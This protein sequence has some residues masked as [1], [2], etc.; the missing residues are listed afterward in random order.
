MRHGL[1]EGMVATGKFRR[2]LTSRAPTLLSRT[3]TSTANARKDGRC[4]SRCCCSSGNCASIS[5]R[6][7]SRE[8]STRPSKGKHHPAMV[9]AE[10]PQWKA[11]PTSRG[12]PLALLHCGGPAANPMA[13][14]GPAAASSSS[15]SQSHSG[16]SCAMVLSMLSRRPSHRPDLAHLAVAPSQGRGVPCGLKVA[17][18]DCAAHREVSDRRRT[19]FLRKLRLA[20]CWFSFQTVRAA[21]M[22]CYNSCFVGPA[23]PTS[24]HPVAC[25]SHVASHGLRQCVL[26]CGAGA[27]VPQ[28]R[29]PLVL[30]HAVGITTCSLRASFFE[31]AGGQLVAS[32]RPTHFCFLLTPRYS[33]H[34][35]P[36]SS[37]SKKITLLFFSAPDSA[38]QLTTPVPHRSSLSTITGPT[39]VIWRWTL[40]NRTSGSTLVDCTLLLFG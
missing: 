6:W 16:L 33:F 35:L 25:A 18:E 34:G 21:Q 9:S 22:R 1:F 40:V 32:P 17:P 30:S 3:S 23:L 29:S 19:V 38:L 27:C 8:T 14:S 39:H 36:S 24:L 11:M 13:K 26:H 7:F 4:A 15:Q 10:P 2:H 5:V 28:G 37:S 20:T 31:H 12:L